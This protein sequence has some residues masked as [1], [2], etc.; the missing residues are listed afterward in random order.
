MS[1]V[2]VIPVPPGLE[3]RARIAERGQLEALRATIDACDLGALIEIDKPVVRAFYEFA[4]AGEPG[5]GSL[6]EAFLKEK[7]LGS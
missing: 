7:K 1:K 4:E 2:A 6:V 3:L 5:L